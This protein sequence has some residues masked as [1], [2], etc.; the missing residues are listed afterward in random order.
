M[1][2]RQD[3]SLPQS[4]WSTKILSTLCLKEFRGRELITIH[5]AENSTE[6]YV[7]LITF[8][9][10]ALKTMQ[11]LS[12]IISAQ[13][14]L[15]KYRLIN[16]LRHTKI[17]W[18]SRPLT[19]M[20]NMWKSPIQVFKQRSFDQ[21][22]PEEQYTILLWRWASQDMLKKMTY[23]FWPDRAQVL[24]YHYTPKLPITAIKLCYH[25]FNKQILFLNQL[26]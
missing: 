26:Q 4:I 11:F 13:T 24:S 6:T 22:N 15:N 7:T 1:L 25:P 9:K 14:F 17:L 12:D 16:S 2:V 5:T 23:L 8:K 19:P 20:D 10:N 18:N 21:I 3:I